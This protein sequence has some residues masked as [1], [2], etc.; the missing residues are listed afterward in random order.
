LPHARPL[1]PVSAVVFDFDGTLVRTDI[2]F[3]SIRGRLR[4]YFIANDCWDEALFQRY[5]LEMVDNVCAR[6]DRQKAQE[7]RREAMEIVH[8]GEVAACERGEPY[9][10]VPEALEELERRGYRLGIFTRNSR[11]CCELVLSRHRL[12]HDVLLTRDD[13]G[14]VKPDPE[15]L[16]QTLAQLGVRPEC[17]LVVGDHHTDVETAVACGAHAAGVLT[18]NGTRERFLESGARLV[19]GSAADLPDV[20]PAKPGG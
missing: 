16:Q 5:I 4:E 9:P 14:N 2:D 6:L 8:A 15:H 3:A 20:L 7:V 13:V 11:T 12:L 18:T 10:G 17:A 19:L 1:P